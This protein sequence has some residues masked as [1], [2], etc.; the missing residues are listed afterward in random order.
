MVKT[1]RRKTSQGIRKRHSQRN[2][3][4]RQRLAKVA[5][6]HSVDGRTS[7]LDHYGNFDG[8]TKSATASELIKVQKGKTGAPVSPRYNQEPD[9][10]DEPI[11]KRRRRGG[12][13]DAYLELIHDIRNTTSGA[14]DLS[15]KMAVNAGRTA[16]KASTGDR[17]PTNC[18]NIA[19][20]GSTRRDIPSKFTLRT[21]Y[22][23]AWPKTRKSPRSVN[24]RNKS[25]SREPTCLVWPRDAKLF[26]SAKSFQRMHQLHRLL[27]HVNL[28]NRTCSQVWARYLGPYPR[29][30]RRIWT[31]WTTTPRRTSTPSGSSQV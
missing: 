16:F 27:L 12:P 10:D 11:G 13:T 17:W 20:P 30:P 1:S 3:P 26:T 31:P 22:P 23:H 2:D 7:S 5:A 9:S 25:W 8:T 24:P 21:E 18:Q 15:G 14:S 28:I 19:R 29:V 4:N 6:R